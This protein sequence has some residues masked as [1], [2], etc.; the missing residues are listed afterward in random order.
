MKLLAIPP[1]CQKTATTCLVNPDRLRPPRYVLPDKRE[2]GAFLKR[3]ADLHVALIFF[4]DFD[5]EAEV[6]HE[7]EQLKEP[8]TD[9]SDYSM[10]ANCQTV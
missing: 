4:A 9:Y 1:D 7:F 2:R 6:R 8:G 5:G 10:C 3:L